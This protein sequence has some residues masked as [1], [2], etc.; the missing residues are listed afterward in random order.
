M[1]KIKQEYI[2]EIC[3]DISKEIILPKYKKLKDHDIKYKNGTDLVTSVDIAAEKEL[4]KQL[5]KIIPNSN[6]VGEEA[7]SENKNILNLYN[8]N[9]YCWTVDPIDGTTNFVKGKDKFAIMIALTY[10]N[11]ILYSWIYKPLID[12]MCYAIYDQGTFIENKKILTKTV[13]NFNQAIGSIST[14]YWEDNYLDQLKILKNNF[15]EVRS[16]GCIG[17]EYIDIALGKRNFAI[18]SKLSPWDHI[19]G[20]LIVREAG[21][22]D[23]DFNKQS[24]NFTL[25]NKN[26]I[27]G[28]SE[29]FNLKILH[30]LG[31]YS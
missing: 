23:F 20:I 14:K 22:A 13:S 30:K 31:E 9:N 10:K 1:D 24:Y 12:E 28:N 18:L 29:Q 25:R 26:L 4:E 6:F 15:A 17:F 21:G 27:V 11:K 7:Y 19:P 16:Y 3:F 5:L 2:R 8:D